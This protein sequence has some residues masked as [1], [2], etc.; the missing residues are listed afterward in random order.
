MERTISLPAAQLFVIAVEEILRR[1]AAN[2]ISASADA[3]HVKQFKINQMC[4]NFTA[5]IVTCKLHA[6]QTKI[7]T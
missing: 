7:T 3:I 6:V 5:I 1:G 2:R 4:V